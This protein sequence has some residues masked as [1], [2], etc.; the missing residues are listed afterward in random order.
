M[1]IHIFP[2]DEVIF[3][4]FCTKIHNVLNKILDV[5]R[6][7][8]NAIDDFSE[9]TDFLLVFLT[10]IGDVNYRWNRLQ[11][12]TWNGRYIYWYN[13]IL[14]NYCTASLWKKNVLNLV[15]PSPIGNFRLLRQISV[16]YNSTQMI[17]VFQTRCQI[18]DDALVIWI[19]AELDDFESFIK[20]FDISCRMPQCFPTMYSI[21]KI[22][23]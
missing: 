18:F 15:Q 12:K 16:Q 5:A 1:R 17:N 10:Y 23:L 11:Y 21:C 13:K 9:Q 2:N 19:H 8:R 4:S 3:G 7:I 14:I 22:I 6:I 20:N